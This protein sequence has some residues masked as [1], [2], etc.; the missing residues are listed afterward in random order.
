[1][2]ARTI[3]EHYAQIS[4]FR[5][6]DNGHKAIMERTKSTGR[7]LAFA[8]SQLFATLSAQS[9]YYYYY[10]IRVKGNDSL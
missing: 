3:V 1:M 9:H 8:N 7:K 2:Y 5:G 4:S 10:K 6:R